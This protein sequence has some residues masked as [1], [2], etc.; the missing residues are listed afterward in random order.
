MTT[1]A[2][3]EQ[4]AIRNESNPHQYFTMMLNMADDDLNPHE[5][6]LLGHYVRW[7]GHG[8]THQESVRQ[9][10]KVTRMGKSTVD[11]MRDALAEKGYIKVIKPSEPDRAEGVATQVIVLDR[12]AENINRYSKAVPNQVEGV[13][14][15]EDTG[16]PKQ[17]HP[18]VPNQVD[19]EEPHAEEPLEELKT[20]API[21]TDPEPNKLPV[22]NDVVKAAE[23]HINKAAPLNLN[24]LY[25][26]AVKTTFKIGFGSFNGLMVNFLTASPKNKGKWKEWQVDDPPMQPIEIVGFGDWYGTDYKDAYKKN[27]DKPPTTPDTLGPRIMEFRSQP[28]YQQYVDRA[29]VAFMAR[30][31]AELPPPEQPKELPQP[32]P[33][34]ARRAEEIIQRLARGE[35][36]NE[37]ATL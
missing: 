33:D 1:R 16:I 32:N 9:T 19:S 15:I 30:M 5:Y 28:D 4:Q 20:P 24:D 12:W 36:I 14:P 21:G 22:V 25:Q 37:L 34:Y 17:G 31:N 2:K 11:K 10:A 8:G 3:A 7:A 29:G 6:R 35:S 23:E 27:K 18:R 26:E 13:Y